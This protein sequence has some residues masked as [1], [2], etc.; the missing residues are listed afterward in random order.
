[1]Y[2]R[3][4]CMIVQNP[5]KNRS[6]RKMPS[7][8]P[9]ILLAL[10]LFT[11]GCSSI[12]P[13]VSMPDL[14]LSPN[15]DSFRNRFYAGAGIGSTLL[16]PDTSAAP[17]FSADDAAAAASQ[18]RIGYDVHNRFAVELDSS[19]LGEASVNETNTASI[20]Y[21]SFGASALYYALGAT[22]NRN[23]R[24]RWNGYG[25]LGIALNRTTSNINPLDQ[26][27]TALVAGFGAEYGMKNGLG[28]RAEVTRFDDE[29]TYLGVGAVFRFDSVKRL[30]PTDLNAEK[31]PE[32]IV[33]DRF[34]ES[35][36]DVATATSSAAEP[37][38]AAAMGPSSSSLNNAYQNGKVTLLASV[39]DRDVDGVP[40][41]VDECKNTIPGTAVD[42]AGCG[43]FDAV[44]EN[45]SFDSGS[46]SLSDGMKV[47]LD[48]LV[49]RLT[50][51]PEVRI[52][53]EGHTDDKGPAEINLNVSR[54]RA[55][56]VREYLIKKGIPPQQLET[57][58]Y[59]ETKPIASNET[60][61]GRNQNRRIALVTLPSLTPQE[62][63]SPVIPHLDSPLPGSN[64]KNESSQTAKSTKDRNK[65]PVMAAAQEGI[66]LLPAT[67]SIPGLEV[68]GV[69]ENVG[70]I[71]KTADLT[72]NSDKTLR[73]VAQVLKKH[74]DAKVLLATHT[75][76]ADS[77]EENLS[78]SDAQAQA[79]VSALVSLGVNRRQLVGRGFGN[80]LPLAQ[81]VT[82]V[83]KA[84]N[85][86][87]ELRPI[88]N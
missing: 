54:S 85:R 36:T 67:L 86:R 30:I 37:A 41:D 11:V 84:V 16:S 7:L 5:A 81:E 20:K 39:S 15:S 45:S 71:E 60:E 1:M 50:A 10:S 70:F 88:K 65:E 52:G 13:Q 9:R 73:V 68:H 18:L 2:A 6:Q 12:S 40:N 21:S 57:H 25:R 38:L 14:S 72:A 27:D 75:N 87:V 29:S 42:T 24:Q 53:I 32:A 48:K 82:D 17:V 35:V 44:I 76:L 33:S 77:D 58:A 3:A 59:G 74:R 49:T 47:S 79:V 19:V 34:N 63:S 46:A 55:H 61:L 56:M 43:L 69:M 26:S 80:T 8:R 31:Q 22:E 23:R 83:D 4:H 64:V 51:F 62:L 66:E 78:L 28:I